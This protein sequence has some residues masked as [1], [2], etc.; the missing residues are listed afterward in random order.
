M[1]EPKAVSVNLQKEKNHRTKAVNHRFLIGDTS[2]NGWNFPL[3][4][5]FSGG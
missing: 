5:L 2:S 3:S 1:L 4:R